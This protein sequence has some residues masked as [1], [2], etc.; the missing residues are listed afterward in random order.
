MQGHDSCSRRFRSRVCQLVKIPDHT[1][2]PARRHL[3]V[4]AR[5]R[6]LS[7][8]PILSVLHHSAGASKPMLRKLLLVV[9]AVV[10]SYGLTALAGYL[11]YMN[12]VG[13]S[14][15]HLSA[16]VRFV[17]SPLIATL[18]GCLVGLL[19][20]DHPIATSIFGLAPWAIMLLSPHEPAS[21]LSWA[22]W[23]VPILVY[24]PLGATAAC[25]SWRYRRKLS[26]QSGSLA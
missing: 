26:G 1:H 18:I 22:E 3:S 5:F 11:V 10:V 9:M 13:R 23:T 7:S 2:P 6:Q 15:G 8:H 25:L 14:E 17:V 19:S 12:S 24:I 16:T 21:I 4:N 20:K